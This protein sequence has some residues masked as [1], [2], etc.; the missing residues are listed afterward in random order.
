MKKIICAALAAFVLTLVPLAWGAD[1][2]DARGAQQLQAEP[3]SGPARHAKRHHH[4]H[5][6]ANKGKKNKKSP[7]G[8]A[9]TSPAEDSGKPV[10][11]Q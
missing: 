10:S 4:K 5:H 6:A 3:N 1:T 7:A 9:Q 8:A 2:S 11:G